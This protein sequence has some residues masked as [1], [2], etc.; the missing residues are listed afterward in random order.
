MSLDVV[1]GVFME[2]PGCDIDLAFLFLNRSI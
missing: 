2:Q 1:T